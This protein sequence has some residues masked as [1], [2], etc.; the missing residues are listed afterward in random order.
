MVISKNSKVA[1]LKLLA[2]VQEF[3]IY[4]P[5]LRHCK[6]DKQKQK[7]QEHNWS[8][9]PILS[10][11]PIFHYQLSVELRHPIFLIL[12]IRKQLQGTGSRQRDITV[13]LLEVIPVHPRVHV[14]G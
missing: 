14:F 9:D 10:L 7:L 6:G 11:R 4:G 13:G 12:V 1:L 2:Q 5:H 8:G 3:L